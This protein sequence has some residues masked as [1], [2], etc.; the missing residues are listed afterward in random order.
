[1]RSDQPRTPRLRR[2]KATACQRCRARKQRCDGQNQG[3]CRNCRSAKA[4][5]NEPTDTYSVS[6]VEDLE[7]QVANLHARLPE[8]TSE[9]TAQVHTGPGTLLA[10]NTQANIYAEVQGFNDPINAFYLPPIHSHGNTDFPFDFSYPDENLFSIVQEPTTQVNNT[11]EPRSYELD[12]SQSIDASAD[13]AMADV[14]VREG[15]SFFQTYFETIH[16][17]Y[18]FLDVEECSTAYLKWKTGEMKICSNK[19][20]P[21]CLLKLIIA[22]GAILQL[23]WLD[24]TGRRQRQKL[25]V[26]EQNILSDT[27]FNPSRRLQVLLLQAL[28]A[29]HGETTER[30]VHIVGVAMRFAILHGFHRLTNDGTHEADMKIKAWWSIYCLDKVAAITLRIPPYPPDEWIE[31]QSYEAKPDPQFFMPWA[32]DIP[33]LSDGVLYSFD[34]RYFAHMCRIRRLH[35]EILTAMRRLPPDS[36]ILRLRGLRAEIDKWTKC[37]EVFANGEGHAS[38]LGVVYVGHMTRFLLYSSVSVEASPEVVDELLQVCCDACATFRAL[39]KRKHLPR[40]WFDMLFIFQIGVTMIYIVWRRNVTVSKAIDRAIRDCTAILS[41]FADRS[42]N[43][44]VY[45]DC[46]DLLAGSVSR[47]AQPVNIDA[48][49]RRELVVLVGQIEENRLAS[50]IHSQ[51]LDMCRDNTSDGQ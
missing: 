42:Q 18:P 25:D 37:E 8:Q 7:Q 21:M 38:P 12:T 27:S 17:R 51:L 30:V 35:S 31:T 1:M 9:T 22:N 46:M 34:L 14:S 40:H 36:E 19:D 4:A 50:H 6:Y 39:Q 43:A 47:A 15:A 23:A 49:S 33:G 28:L 20:W 41:I 48:E 16:P 13:A 11:V 44:D 5:T 2:K 26:E 10:P 29:L 24:H 45:R 3:A 32:A